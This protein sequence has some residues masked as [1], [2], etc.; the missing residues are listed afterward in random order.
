VRPEDV[1]AYNEVARRVMQSNGIAIDDLYALALPRLSTLQLK[2]NVHFTTEGYEA[3]ARQVAN[4]V[5]AALG[6]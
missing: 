1:V 2:N 4:S 5:L 3:L 6:K